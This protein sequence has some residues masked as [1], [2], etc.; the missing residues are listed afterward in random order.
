MT[1]TGQIRRAS[2]IDA[3]RTH[4]ICM[5][6]IRDGYV[7]SALVKFDDGWRCLRMVGASSYMAIW[8]KIIT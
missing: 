8:L 5:S 4:D 7:H 1:L 6:L 3:R 2:R